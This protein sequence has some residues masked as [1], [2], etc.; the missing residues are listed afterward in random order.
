MPAPT[1][2]GDEK[3]DEKLNPGQ[4]HS[5]HQLNDLSGAE[6]RGTIDMSDFERN[7]GEN[8]DGSAEDANI[9]K[10]RNAESEGNDTGGWATNISPGG[11]GKSKLAT[12]TGWIKKRGPVV[13][14]GGGVGIIA[15][16]FSSFLGTATLLPGLSQSSAA[17]NDARGSILERR[18]VAA[19]EQKMGDKSGP[20]DTKIA[21]CR[22]GKMPKAMLS[23]M[24]EKNITAVNADGTKFA[25]DGNGYVDENP[26]GYEIDDG[27]GGTR[28]VPA[29]EFV[30]E[31][32]GNAAFRKAVKKVYNMRYL[33]YSGKYFVKNFF[34]P[35]G[36]GRDGGLAADPD[37]NE[38][39]IDEKL[40]EKLKT[41]AAGSNEGDTAKK[42]FRERA[43]LLLKRGADRTKKSGGDPIL[44]VGAGACMA[45]GMPR[46]VA[47]TYRVIQVAQLAVL[48]QDLVLS[49]GGMQ[50][51][52]DG[53]SENIAAIGNKLTE[54][55]ENG[56]GKL[57]SALDSAI[58]LSAI[59]VNTNKV[60]VSKFAPGYGLLSNPGVQVANQ[61]ADNTKETCDL[62]N[63]PQ[64]AFAV[65]GIEGAISV[66]TA[67]V[68]AVIIG[69]LKAVGKLA[70]VFGAIEGLMAAA[71]ATG[72][73]D[74]V[75]DVAYGVAKDFIGNYLEGA[76]G[77]DLGDALGTSMYSYY[78]LAGSA[79]GAA[80]LKTSQVEGFQEVMAGVENDIKNEDIATLSPFDTSS[81]Y[82]FAGSIAYNLATIKYTSSNPLIASFNMLGS[83]ISS[84]LTNKA[85]AQAST[86]ES[87]CGY[88]EVF[89]INKD[90]AVNPAGY[91]CVGIPKEY[92]NTDRST[93]M[94]S[95]LSD[96]DEKTGEP[97]KDRNDLTGKTNDISSMMNDCSQGDLESITGCTI[98][99][100]KAASTA[101]YVVC[102][103]YVEQTGC[104]T[105]SGSAGSP[106]DKK[107][108]ALSLYS[109]DLQVENILAGKD[110]EESGSSTGVAADATI[111]MANIYEDSTTVSCA[112]GTDDAGVDR[113]FRDKVEIPVQLCSI[114]NTDQAGSP[115]RVN[116]RI[117]GAINA[118]VIKLKTD[119]G[120]T[121]VKFADSFR[122]ME[123]QEHAWRCAS[124]T[125][126]PGEDCSDIAGAAAEPGTSRHQ[127]GIA[128][129]FQLPTD[130]V[131]ATRPGDPVWDWLSANAAGFGFSS[132]VGESWHWSADGN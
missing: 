35:L 128:L 80:V 69:A 109:F 18:L 46:F 31:Y 115:I 29:A 9:D 127:L 90:I 122:T 100:T 24:A 13:G 76:K 39:S 78:S 85:S 89:G 61:V 97:I 2:S 129:D 52:G 103:D 60:G 44:M 96:I 23:A 82:T 30:A 107:R 94:N 49:P 17:E 53:K 114:P 51:A 66:G 121:T 119:L 105:V 5:D 12:V 47:G 6:K 26:H 33:G 130:N 8:A 131:G 93:V 36:L 81:K 62:I 84:Q 14:V 55:T 20:C 38:S 83:S 86:V 112:E 95:V 113:G 77:E 72:I 37:V 40:E 10:L 64:A 118:L 98:D 48:L 116:S 74:N 124:G 11:S 120:L 68:G 57:S 125:R 34:K 42:A 50:Q 65:A 132:N 102:E 59:G 43:K 4:Q 126:Q 106:D 91:A 67:G 25:I 7:Y 101:S 58:L 3:Q 104:E 110:V 99:S 54:R 108:A 45:I 27:K 1:L 117:S 75:A 92:I 41:P 79:G 111:D 21:T 16:L 88:A 56:N 28:T 22:A 87:K 63:S 32:K 123:G 15:I 71:E 19:L 73:I 70:I